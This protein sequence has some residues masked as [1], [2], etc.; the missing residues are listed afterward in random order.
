MTFLC[1]SFIAPSK[2]NRYAFARFK[3]K[4]F[5]LLV[6]IPDSAYLGAI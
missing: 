2:A 1:I 3:V 5:L 6:L 4:S